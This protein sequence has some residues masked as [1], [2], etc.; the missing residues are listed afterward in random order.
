MS[1]LDDVTPVDD[2]KKRGCCDVDDEE[3]IG[4]CERPSTLFDTQFDSQGKP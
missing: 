2:D 1:F 4:C 3:K